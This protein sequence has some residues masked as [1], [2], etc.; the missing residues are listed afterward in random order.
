M[1]N[2][3][4]NYPSYLALYR[5]SNPS[6]VLRQTSLNTTR[7]T[8]IIRLSSGRFET[9]Q[10]KTAY[11]VFTGAKPFSLYEKV[12]MKEFLKD[13]EPAFTSPSSTLVK[14]RLLNE[15]YEETWKEVLA[16]IKKND[17]LNVSTDKSA[18]ATK[19]RVM[20]F[21]ILYNLGS[22]C[23][24]QGAVPTGEFRAEK[25]ADWLEAQIKALKIRYK[26]EF[27]QDAELPPINSVSTDTCSTIRSM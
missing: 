8:P 22:F 21:S 3:L 5:A 13:L 1:K 2:H 11:A 26:A 14:G 12:D 15:C 20:N 10:K 23:I 24:K 7:V 27:R 9:L 17:S 6:L 16:V 4:T 25:Q 18:T 19:E